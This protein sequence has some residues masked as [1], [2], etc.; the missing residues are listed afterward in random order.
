MGSVNPIL[1]S[2]EKPRISKKNWCRLKNQPLR[3]IIQGIRRSL[4]LCM[5]K[6]ASKL[7]AD[8][9]QKSVQ[10]VTKTEVPILNFD[11]FLP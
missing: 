2:A 4:S 7:G 6:T 5:L 3:L 11:C 1:A 9:K 8:S 10:T